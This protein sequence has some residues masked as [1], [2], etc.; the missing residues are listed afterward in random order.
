M[1]EILDEISAL[2]VSITTGIWLA[3]IL[4]FIPLSI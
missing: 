3:G 1:P 4:F 2:A